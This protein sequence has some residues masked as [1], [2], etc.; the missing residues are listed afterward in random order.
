MT[1]H[2]FDSRDYIFW[3]IYR[4]YFRKSEVDIHKEIQKTFNLTVSKLRE[5]NIEYAELKNILTPQKNK[6][7]IGFIFDST[8]IDNTSYG[9]V[10]LDNFK[11]AIGSIKNSAVFF[12][13]ITAG[14]SRQAQLNIRT[15]MMDEVVLF[16]DL[17]FKHATQYFVVYFN[18]LTTKILNSILEKLH[19]VSYFVGYADHS[20]GSRLKD[21]VSMSIGQQFLLHKGKAL[22]AH[23]DGDAEDV[24]HTIFDFENTSINCVSIDDNLYNS[25]LRYKI[26]RRYFNMD[27]SDQLFSVNSVNQE[28]DIINGYNI[29]IEDSKL[30]YL[31]KNKSGSIKKIVGDDFSKQD[32]IHQIAANINTNYLFNLDLNEYGCLKFNTDIEFRDKIK[33]E[34]SRCIASFEILM[35]SK[36]FRLITMY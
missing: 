7:E 36:Q 32:L 2:T 27:N 28:V 18:N 3:E 1:I 8:K 23:A 6:K 9:I 31:V 21:V 4:D 30:E 11:I 24:N 26:K 12:G 34:N 16:N 10:V 17:N 20:Y 19:T 14:H 5:K 15:A 29:I 33:N 35:Q 13:D 25:F 22:Q